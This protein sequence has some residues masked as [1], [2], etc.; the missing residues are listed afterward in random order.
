MSEISPP[1]KPIETKNNKINEKHNC[2]LVSTYLVP[3]GTS[4]R[5]PQGT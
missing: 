2:H 1:Q 4:I 3:G 5:G